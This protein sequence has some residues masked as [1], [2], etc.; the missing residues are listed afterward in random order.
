[1]IKRLSVV[2]LAI[3]I[4]VSGCTVLRPA[5]AGN[6]PLA[7]Q[8]A[9]QPAPTQ[10]AQ[11]VAPARTAPPASQPPAATLSKPPPTA[12]GPSAVT[13]SPLA[14]QTL[15]VWVYASTPLENALLENWIPGFESAHPGVTI[16]LTPI[17]AARVEDYDARLS[18][19]FSAG[20][21]PDVWLMGD[22]NYQQ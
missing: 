15:E 18:I 6:T 7:P 12:C 21:G 9:S 19:A 8:S 4:L 5:P 17:P 11:P 16:N 10:A 22:W 13:P 3:A 1:M 14:P 2:L 20:S